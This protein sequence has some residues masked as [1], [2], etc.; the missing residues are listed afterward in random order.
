M[1]KPLERLLEAWE[2]LPAFA[3]DLVVELALQLADRPST[4][5]TVY[6][7]PSSPRKTRCPECE[8]EIP[9]P[10]HLFCGDCGAPLFAASVI[11]R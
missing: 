2:Q 6:H 9:D 11:Q 1:L 5:K 7:P 4:R 8:L 3:Q 10:T